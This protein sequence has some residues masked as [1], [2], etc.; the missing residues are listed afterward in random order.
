MTEPEE[1][2]SNKLTI[3]RRKFL[4]GSIVGI[5]SLAVAGCIGGI[6]S[7]NNI[8]VTERTI[9]I[10]NLPPEF[11]NTTIT[12][13]SDIHSSPYMVLADIKHI[14]DI[15]QS[16]N[17]DIILLPGDFVTTHRDELPPVLEALSGLHAPLGVYATTGNHEF[18][19]DPDL[20][21]EGIANLG[22]TIIRNGNIA[23]KKNGAEL[24]ILGVDDIDA[25]DI[26]HHVEG[27]AAPHIDALFDGVPNEA[28]TILMCHKPYRFEEYAKTNVGLMVS[29]HTH[30]G[31][32]VFAR[33]GKTVICPS[34]FASKYVEGT[35][36]SKQPLSRTQLYVS[37]GLGTVALPM[38]LNCPPEITKITLA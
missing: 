19:V 12:L 21:S 10:P 31:Q 1:L 36:K 20:V 30:G 18:Y 5:S 34:V 29:G 2:S 37:R 32:I 27:K 38:R 4:Y 11:K 7:R 15:I 25:D 3:S 23:I 16:L 8:E 13:A 14:A 6:A 9:T 22:I 28:A 33:F 35:F 26:I 17:S 24:Y